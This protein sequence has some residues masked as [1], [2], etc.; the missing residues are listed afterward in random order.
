MT[1]T[2]GSWPEVDA[3]CAGPDRPV[4]RQHDAQDVP[5]HDGPDLDV[6]DQPRRQAR[7]VDGVVVGPEQVDTLLP[8]R[9]AGEDPGRL[10]S[11]SSREK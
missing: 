1:A 8:E 4:V 3:E 2:S 11:S 9:V 5:Q 7:V 6:G 10:A